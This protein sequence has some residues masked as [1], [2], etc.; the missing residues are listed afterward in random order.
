MDTLRRRVPPRLGG[1]RDWSRAHPYTLTYLAVHA[2]AAGRIDDLIGDTEYLVHAQPDILA[3]AIRTATT[4][5]GRLVR[6]MYLTSAG[7]HRT[8]DTA[9]RRDIL[10][11]DAARCAA[12]DQLRA[13]VDDSDFPVRWATGGMIHES[14]R[15]TLT[16]HDGWVYAVACT[17]LDG[18]PVAVTGGSDGTVRLWDLAGG[19]QRAMLTGHDG[20][21]Y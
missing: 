12:S 13:L 3:T 18:S 16:G 19:T 4:P 20:W 2:A 9:T 7:V 15:A 17:V 21:V 5:A 1:G 14:L 6:T 10:A 8:A 11:V